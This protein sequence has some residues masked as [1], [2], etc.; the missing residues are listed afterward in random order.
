MKKIIFIIILLLV[1]GYGWIGIFKPQT[2]KIFDKAELNLDVYITNVKEKFIDF[3]GI[4]NNV[5]D[6]YLDDIVKNLNQQSKDK[7]MQWLED[8]KVPTSTI[9]ILDNNT[10]DY[11]Q[12]LKDNPGLVE[13]LKEFSGVNK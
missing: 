1:I 11:K 10:I 12:L 13:S 2:N 6:R 3:V 4:F 7:I 8:N 9:K 5:S